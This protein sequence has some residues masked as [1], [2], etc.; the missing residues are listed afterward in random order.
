MH[1]CARDAQLIS[2]HVDTLVRLNKMV[3]SS[4]EVRKG[5]VRLLNLFFIVVS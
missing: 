5:S 1:T 3:D 2:E 4:A